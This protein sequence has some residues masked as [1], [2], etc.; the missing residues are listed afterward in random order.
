MEQFLHQPRRAHKTLIVPGVHLKIH[1][2]LPH[3]LPLPGCCCCCRGVGS[4]MKYLNIIDNSGAFTKWPA[5]HLAP[6][7]NAC[8]RRRRRRRWRRALAR[9]KYWC[10]T[11]KTV[12]KPSSGFDGVKF[13]E[14]LS[15][16]ATLI[17]EIPS[18]ASPMSSRGAIEA[19]E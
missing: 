1:P 19:Y 3:L 12:V 11:P 7:S 16:Y 6:S 14:S 5:A 10:S 2:R 15:N 9:S 18:T 13:L 8:A 17:A 4:A